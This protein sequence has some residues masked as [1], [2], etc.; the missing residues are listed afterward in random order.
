MVL[1]ISPRYCSRRRNACFYFISEICELIS[2][3]YVNNF[4]Y[5][6]IS[7]FHCDIKILYIDYWKR[8]CVPCVLWY[9]NIEDSGLLLLALLKAFRIM[10]CVKIIFNI[11]ANEIENY[12]DLQ[13]LIVVSCTNSIS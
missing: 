2:I 5:Q 8:I 12:L 1:I 9:I 7:C 3:Y 4:F 13:I 6:I 10:Q 11:F